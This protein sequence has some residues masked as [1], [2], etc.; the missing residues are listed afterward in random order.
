MLIVFGMACG[1]A[2]SLTPWARQWGLRQGLAAT[3]GG[4]RQHQ[5]IMPRTGGLP[6]GI[7]FLAAIFIAQI[8]PIERTDPKEMIRFV[9][10]VLGGLVILGV[11]LLDDKYDL[12]PL[13]LYIG[14]LLSAALAVVFLI[15][16]ET[17]N[18]PL[19]GET[20][21]FPYWFT[22]T[23]SL[24]WMGIMMNTVNFLDGSD[25]LAAGVTGIAALMIFF[26]AGFRL[27]QVSVSLLAVA[28]V[29]AI[30][31]FLPYNFQ[32]ASIFLGGGAYLLGYL[33]GVLS[34]IGGAK[35]ATILLVMGLPLMDL[36]WQASRR[37]LQGQNP[38]E[39]DRGH[40]HFRLIDIGVPHWAVALGYYS[41][42]AFFGLI[43]LTTASQL[44]KLLA[45]MVMVCIV[46]FVFVVMSVRTSSSQLTD[47]QSTD[48]SPHE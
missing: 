28:L 10:L 46:L 4:R 36:A 14:Q 15:F 8:L 39:G 17:F 42:C 22:V 31:G 7:A 21:H 3:P 47:T 26:H 38:M 6:I 1:L 37:I 20:I 45:L 29:G 32:P 44:F 23:I 27:D 16:I 41:F 2:W 11:G 35:M 30:V 9:G 43:A 19:T 5:G 40:L 18:N 34:I 24:F 25:G 12:S 33:L 13:V 48:Y